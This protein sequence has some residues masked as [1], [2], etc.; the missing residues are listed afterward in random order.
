MQLADPQGLLLPCKQLPTTVAA[1]DVRDQQER[2]IQ[3]LLFLQRDRPALPFGTGR[4][5]RADAA[6]LRLTQKIFS[7]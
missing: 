1:L 4:T 5:D 3:L 7:E 2:L 6:L